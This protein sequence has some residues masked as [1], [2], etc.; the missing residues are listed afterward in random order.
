V[1]S[2]RW[3]VHRLPQRVFDLLMLAFATLA[4]LRLILG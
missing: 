4:A 1:L 2:G 3:I